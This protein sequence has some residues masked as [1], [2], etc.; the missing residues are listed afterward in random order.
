MVLSLADGGGGGVSGKQREGL[1]EG[2]GLGAE[3]TSAAGSAWARGGWRLKSDE[4]AVIFQIDS[5]FW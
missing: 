1:H 4:W 5:D 3:S 2:G